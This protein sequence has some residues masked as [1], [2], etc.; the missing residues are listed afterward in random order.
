MPIDKTSSS[1]L[2]AG[3][4]LDDIRVS[5]ILNAFFSLGIDAPITSLSLDSNQLTRVPDQISLF[6]KLEYLNLNYNLITTVTTGS[7]NIAVPFELE[8]QYNPTLTIIEAG[9][10]QG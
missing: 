3:F 5:Q 6:S 7:L 1:L 2:C 10:F 9:A 4:D 8:L